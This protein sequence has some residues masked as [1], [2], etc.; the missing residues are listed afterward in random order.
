[1]STR[2]INVTVYRFRV[3]RFRFGVQGSKVLTS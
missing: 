3:Q 1:M 2:K